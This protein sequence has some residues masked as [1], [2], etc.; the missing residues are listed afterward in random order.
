MATMLAFRLKG[1]VVYNPESGGVILREG[2]RPLRLNLQSRGVALALEDMS[3]C[4]FPDVAAERAAEEGLAAATSVHAACNLLLRFRLLDVLVADTD[5]TIHAVWSGAPYAPVFDEYVE[6]PGEVLLNRFA[7]VRREGEYTVVDSALGRAVVEC[8]SARAVQVLCHAFTGLSTT[9]SEFSKLI[10]L[11]LC[12]AT[13]CEHQCMGTTAEAL[14]SP[15]DLLFHTRSRFGSHPYPFG[16]AFRHAGTIDPPSAAPLRPASWQKVELP[17][18]RPLP[19]TGFAAVLESRHSVRVWGAQPIPLAVLSTLLWH[20]MRA[21]AVFDMEVTPEIRYRLQRKAYPSGGAIYEVEGFLFVNNVE[22]LEQ[23]CYWYAS[24]E[25]CLY[26]VPDAREH[27]PLVT[28]QARFA[29]GA[30]QD[31]PA[32][33]SFASRFARMQ[34]KYDAIAYA[35]MAKNVGAL[36]QTV[37][38]VGEALGLGICGLG[39]GSIDAFCEATGLDW[40]EEGSIGEMALGLPEDHNFATTTQEEER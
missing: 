26:R 1:D 19:P 13:A 34:W 29:M 5:G 20:T 22:G 8:R 30:R 14:W 3:T 24:Q 32:V 2:Y 25:H 11:L 9:H 28:L 33:L 40:L 7:F 17:E 6:L 4:F 37:Y 21:Q 15:F 10:A 38:L 27:L 23:G 16:G 18:A 31:P 39:S 35:A 12:N 36:Y